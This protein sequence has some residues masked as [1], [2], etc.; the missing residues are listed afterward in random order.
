MSCYSCGSAF[1]LFKKE[2]GCKN[3]GYA[4]CKDCL[5]KKAEIP[6]LKNEKHKVCLKCYNILTGQVQPENKNVKYSPPEALRKR[7]AKLE[8]KAHSPERFRAKPSP[9][10]CK[11]MNTTGM[12]KEDIA[13]A[14]RL[15]KLKESRKQK[16]RTEAQQVEDLLLEICEEVDIDSHQINYAEDVGNRLDRLRALH[17][18]P[19][20]L[21]NNLNS[22]D[23]KHEAHYT[24][25]IPDID[26]DYNSASGEN[27]DWSEMNHLIREVATELEVDAARAIQGLKQDK[28]LWN[29]L[30]KLREKKE[31]KIENLDEHPN[32]GICG[33]PENE[34]EQ[35]EE[36]CK[37][38]IREGKLSLDT[39]AW[40][41]LKLTAC[42]FL[43]EN[44]EIPWY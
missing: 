24:K 1:G 10:E 34:E 27:V 19:A 30:A 8:Q 23:T 9:A 21:Q 4:F 44:T 16:H 43:V 26:N 36:A 37:N 12:S 42:I 5:T 38:I 13:I 17:D 18:T 29:R 14:V 35:E 41:S 39:E 22:P 20:E 28:D 33:S 6:K 40:Y 7:L 3:C 25:N 2:F 11:I 15:Q 31:T 32:C